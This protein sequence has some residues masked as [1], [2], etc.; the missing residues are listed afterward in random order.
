MARE[1]PRELEVY[2]LERKKSD[3]VFVCQ[4]CGKGLT[5]KASL[6]AHLKS[7]HHPKKCPYCDEMVVGINMRKHVAVKH[8]VLAED[9]SHL[10]CCPQC[11]KVLGKKQLEQHLEVFH[12]IRI[13]ADCQKPCE[14]VKSYML[15]RWYVHD[16]K[17]YMGGKLNYPSGYNEEKT[18]STTSSVPSVRRRFKFH[19]LSCTFSCASRKDLLKHRVMYHPETVVDAKEL[20]MRPKYISKQEA[21]DFAM[22]QQ[23]QQQQQQQPQDGGEIDKKKAAA[24]TAN[25]VSNQASASNA[26]IVKE[27]VQDMV[28]EE[29]LQ[30]PDQ[31]KTD[32]NS[33]GNIME[34]MRTPLDSWPDYCFQQEF[35]KPAETVSQMSR[36][37]EP[38]FVQ[39]QQQQQQQQVPMVQ[40]VS[41]DGSVQKFATNCAGTKFVYDAQEF[42]V[43][44]EGEVDNNSNIV[45]KN[46]NED[47]VQVQYLQYSRPEPQIVYKNGSKKDPSQVFS[48]NE[49]GFVCEEVV[50]KQA[51]PTD[52]RFDQDD[53]MLVCLGDQATE[54]SSSSVF[55]WQQQPQQ[56]QDQSLICEVVA[57]TC[58][59]CWK[60]Y[61]KEEDFR[62]HECD[63]QTQPVASSSSSSVVSYGVGFD[64][65][66]KVVHAPS[67]N[68]KNA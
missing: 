10:T 58:A 55:A 8:R 53:Q 19:C 35:N 33:N 56:Q 63:V 21:I 48:G 4:Y 41:Q 29:V 44:A 68:N 31:L 59:R 13:C 47:D 26:T 66:G 9:D 38:L 20:E 57:F 61:L 54:S 65:K 32:N 28:S 46:H 36:D 3:E 45:W 27:E 14:G 11:T 1:H 43:T 17:R 40:Y 25:Y 23:Q 39:Q 60:K 50:C 24:P 12:K 16:D 7:F 42:V 49:I 34:L 15:H 51:C 30:Q 37:A 22:K 52:V 18:K 67:N 64:S 6:N 62:R 2:D 5:K